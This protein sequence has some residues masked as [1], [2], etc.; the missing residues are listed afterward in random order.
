MI[1]VYLDPKGYVNHQ[2]TPTFKILVGRKS[3][4]LSGFSGFEIRV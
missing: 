2:N 3:V 1:I 4:S